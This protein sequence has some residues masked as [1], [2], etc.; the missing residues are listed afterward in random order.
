[1]EETKKSWHRNKK[2]PL[3][4]T[5]TVDMVEAHYLDRNNV[6]RYTSG[7][8]APPFGVYGDG[9]DGSKIPTRGGHEY[10]AWGQV[11]EAIPY[12]RIV[13]WRWK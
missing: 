10:N 6:L 11:G 4:A 13:R 9:V 7:L 2:E 3:E 1:M 5:A 8:N 12:E